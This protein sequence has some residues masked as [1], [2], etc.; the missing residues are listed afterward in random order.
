MIAQ[1]NIGLVHAAHTFDPSR[2]FKFIS[3][4]VWHIRKEILLYLSQNMR[5]VKIPQNIIT[6]LAAIRRVE[7][8][9]AQTEGR[10]PTPIEIEEQLEG[11]TRPVKADKVEQILELDARSIHLEDAAGDDDTFSPINWLNNG[12]STS[13]LIEGKDRLQMANTILNSLTPA[14]KLV[15]SMR[16]GLTDGHTYSFSEIGDR[17]ERTSECARQIFN[18]G[19]RSAKSKIMC[20]AKAREELMYLD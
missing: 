2:G 13:A 4:A 17:I 10:L 11:T 8:S 19:L 18:K 7:S 16:L 9:Y 1:G 20:S 6:D 3:Y 15:I 14:Q 5:T 12:E